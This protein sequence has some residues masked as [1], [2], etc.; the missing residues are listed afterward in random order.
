MFADDV[1]AT[2]IVTISTKEVQWDVTSRAIHTLNHPSA[3][4]GNISVLGTPL[5]R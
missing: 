5:D 2:S 4:I 1:T 3:F